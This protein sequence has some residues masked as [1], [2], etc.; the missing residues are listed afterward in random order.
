MSTADLLDLHRAWAWVM[1]F[2]NA[3]AGVWAL[4]AHWLERLRGRALW[5]FTGV[6]QATIVVQV[7]LGVILVNRDVEAPEFH[8][9]YGFV[10]IIAAVLIYSYR[11]YTPAV[12]RY[13]YVLYGLGGLFLMGLGLRAIYL[14]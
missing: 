1:V 10:A 6:A 3:L 4:A 12:R 2:G 8:E 9:F 11:T 7:V 13:Q 14:A 5:I